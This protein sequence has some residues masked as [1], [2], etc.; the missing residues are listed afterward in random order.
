MTTKDLTSGLQGKRRR[1][2][3]DLNGRNPYEL[4]NE[5]ELKPTAIWILDFLH[6]MRVARSKQII[7][8]CGGNKRYIQ[9]VLQMLT[10]KRFV[11]RFFPKVDVGT[12]QGIY[13]LDQLGAH[14]ISAV[15]E[16]QKKLIWDPRDNLLKEDKLVH[17]LNITEIRAALEMDVK[18]Y[19]KQGLRLERFHGEKRVGR[20]NYQYLGAHELNPDGE[21]RL[22]RQTGEGETYTKIMSIFL[23]EYDRGTE[24]LG[25][26]QE[27]LKKYRDYYGSHEYKALYTD[28]DY[29]D[30]TLVIITHGDLSE[31]RFKKALAAEDGPGK[32]TSK[33][34]VK[35][36]RYEDL[37]EAPVK[38]LSSKEDSAKKLEQMENKTIHLSNT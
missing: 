13:F 32:L 16:T 18:R 35:L 9:Q 19:N 17:T 33:A 7:D 38:R 25:K 5:A 20:R 23:I 11:D 14:Y 28:Q 22:V 21:I 31:Q 3:L 24:D 2:R 15:N 27:K 36:I 29:P 6:D 8:A 37:L 4:I 30:P 10:E 34:K 12:G 26:V 1:P